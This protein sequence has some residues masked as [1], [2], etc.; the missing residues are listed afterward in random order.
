MNTIRPAD[1]FFFLGSPAAG[2]NRVARKGVTP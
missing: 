1:A 2:G